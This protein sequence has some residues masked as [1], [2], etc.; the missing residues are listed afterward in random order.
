M[1]PIIGKTADWPRRI[2]RALERGF[3]VAG[4]KYDDC[5]DWA[6]FLRELGWSVLIVA[7]FYVFTWLCFL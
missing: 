5:R 3:L 7:G 4:D 6:S 2:A 1:T